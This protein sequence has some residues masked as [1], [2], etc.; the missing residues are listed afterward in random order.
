MALEVIENKKP[1]SVGKIESPR[2]QRIISESTGLAKFN[3]TQKIQERDESNEKFAQLEQK[4]ANEINHDTK[5]NH[6]FG[7][8]LSSTTSPIRSKDSSPVKPKRDHIGMINDNLMLELASKQREVLE[9]KT[10]LEQLKLNLQKS[11]KELW[12]IEKKCNRTTASTLPPALSPI[13]PRISN[14]IPQQNS[15]PQQNYQQHYQPRSVQPTTIR[16][17]PSISTFKASIEANISSSTDNFE[18][19]KKKISITQLNSRPSLMNLKS[20]QKDTNDMFNK[21]LHAF[22]NFKSELMKVNNN[23]SEEDDDDYESDVSDYGCADTSDYQ[24][25]VK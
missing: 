11:E 7:L 23:P 24:L 17:K 14:R 12:E 5:T 8:K 3:I 1:M 22:T 21:G 18:R 10:Q 2:R 13:R 4:V 9:Y 25:A 20:L 16:Q 6:K 15:K 19:L